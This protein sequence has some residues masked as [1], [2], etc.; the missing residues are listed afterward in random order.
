MSKYPVDEVNKKLQ[1]ALY[2]YYRLVIIVGPQ[3]SGKSTLLRKIQVSMGIPM[4]NFSLELSKRML[5]LTERQRI[6]GISRILDE[7]MAYTPNEMIL[8]DNLEILFDITLKQNPLQ[9]LKALSRNRTVIAAWN[10]SIEDGYLTYA[11]PRHPEYRRYEIQDF[12]TVDL[13]QFI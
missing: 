10:G 4:V 5:N 2:L 6:L 12:M 3:G 1:Q 8:L 11:V 7:I 9:I 13:A